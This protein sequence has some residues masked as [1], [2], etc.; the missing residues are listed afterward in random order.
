MAT[1]ST[2]KGFTIQSL[3]T[4]PYASVTASGAW[5][6]G[7][8]MNTKR[9]Y[10]GAAGTTTASLVIGGLAP[11]TT[12]D[13]VESYNGTT[14]TELG[15]INT[16]RGIVAS[17][18]I[19]TAA[20]IAGGN[21]PPDLDKAETFNGTTWTEIT[22]MTTGGKCSGV[23]TTT[24][25]LAMAKGPPPSATNESWNGSA[26]TE[27]ADMNAVRYYAS[28]VGATG[29]ALLCVGGQTTAPAYV[30]NVESFN[31]TAWTALSALNTGRSTLGT[32]GTTT[33]ALAYAGGSP[34]K[35]ET[36]FYDGSA[37][38]E[39]GN[40]ASARYG[41]S[42]NCSTQSANTAFCT[43]GY[44][45]PASPTAWQNV[46][47]EWTTASPVSVAQE[48]QVWYNTASNV[49]KGFKAVLG[50]GVWASGGVLNTGRFPIGGA[51]NAPATSTGLGFGGTAPGPAK[52][53]KTESY[54]GTSWTEKGDLNDARI[55]MSGAGTAT[56]ALG[57][58]GDSPGYPTA[59]E[60]FN[61][62]SWTVV[63]ATLTQ[64]KDSAAGFGLQTAAI[65]ATGYAG[66]PAGP[67]GN[68]ANV[69]SYNGSAWTEVNNVNTKRSYV[70]G[71]GIQTSGI[72]AGG[73][74]PPY[75][76]AAETWNGTCWT[77]V[78]SINT[79]RANFA[80][81]GVQ[82]N[83]VGSG[84]DDGSTPRFALVEA[85]DGT[86]WT[87]V[88]NLASANKM[89]GSSGTGGS[90]GINFGGSDPGNNPMTRTEEWTV[91]PATLTIKT[92]TSS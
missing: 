49:M 32:S 78:T 77:T 89:S 79:A 51:T 35:N 80:M 29:T 40:L 10:A 25:L 84:G 7:T 2:L 59:T 48:G 38:T 55:A 45:P 27:V 4:D 69:G 83:A 21:A 53:G 44:N 19:Q 28:G 3:A 31:G 36:E 72:I 37:W 57:F 56:A 46:T 76:A 63:P 58:G 81:F 62:T 47:E 22:D 17:G 26:W 6:S 85:Y 91:P 11:P 50:T 61:G 34:T 71:C 20:I 90:A 75:S 30:A 41:V 9:G 87:E 5:S 65:F 23:G 13:E 88:A 66:P 18:G 14:W 74:G 73:S 12:V 82:T 92:F 15:D 86:T 8:A 67:T 39:L 68:T 43:G 54:D 64:G 70:Y 33:L 52:T 42:A 24:S 16:A 60:S 1:Y